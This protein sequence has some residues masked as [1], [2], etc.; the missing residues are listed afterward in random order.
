VK[1]ALVIAALAA[2]GALPCSA[3][4]VSD[5]ALRA[6]IERN[7]V[8]YDTPADAVAAQYVDIAAACRAKLEQ[9]DGATVSVDGASR[10]S[11]ESADGAAATEPVTPRQ[12][13]EARAL[14]QQTLRAPRSVAGS[15]L[16]GP[17]SLPWPFWTFI[18]LVLA[19]LIAVGAA[20][21]RQR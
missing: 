3:A 21:W 2:L 13:A 14:V 12:R 6:C 16:G 7:G 4:A 5:A 11:G 20:Q 18:T 15:P 8:R 1:N 17:G 10:A 9:G 19:C